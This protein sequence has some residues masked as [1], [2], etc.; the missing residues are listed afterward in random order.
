MTRASDGLPAT[1]PGAWL[2]RWLGALFPRWA[3]RR[4]RDQITRQLVV[5][6]YEAAAGGRRTQG[7]KKPA[8][9]PNAAALGALAP[10][11]NVARDVVRNNAFAESALTA[12]VDHVVGWGI[13]GT[14][15]KGAP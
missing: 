14:P 9:D 5:R 1:L 8:T 13:V 11:R 3:L 6:H 15:E 2:D 10:T 7:W 4:A 12:I